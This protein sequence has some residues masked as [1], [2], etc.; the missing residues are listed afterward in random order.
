MEFDNNRPFE[1]IR[2]GACAIIAFIFFEARAE[3]KGGMEH[4]R[5]ENIGNA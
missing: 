5:T 2:K 1:E 3:Q 4:Q